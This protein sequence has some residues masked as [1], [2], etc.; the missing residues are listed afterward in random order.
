MSAKQNARV[1]V[2][3]KQYKVP[4]PLRSSVQLRLLVALVNLLYCTYMH[5]TYCQLYQYEHHHPTE[6]VSH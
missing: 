1:S 3:L 4:S 2:I 5:C 6:F